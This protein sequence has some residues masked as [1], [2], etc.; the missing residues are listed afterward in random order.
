LGE[1]LFILGSE[2]TAKESTLVGHVL[3][4][5]GGRGVFLESSGKGLAS[6]WI[7]LNWFSRLVFLVYDRHRPV[8]T[9][10]IGMPRIDV[11]SFG[12]VELAGI[13]IKE[14]TQ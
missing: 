7:H 3:E 12:P 9:E 2:E 4:G 1:L 6:L 14:R 8:P 11:C 5:L 10:E 13:F